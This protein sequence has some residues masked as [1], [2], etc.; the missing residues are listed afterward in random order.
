MVKKKNID[1]VEP[2]KIILTL[3]VPSDF[4]KK[5]DNIIYDVIQDVGEERNLNIELKIKRE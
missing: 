3:L 1:K 5:Y 4:K 2:E